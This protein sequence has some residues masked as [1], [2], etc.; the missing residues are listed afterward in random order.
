MEASAII[1]HMGPFL[2]IV[3]PSFAG[4]TLPPT[5]RPESL[6]F[7]P[8]HFLACVKKSGDYASLND[9]IAASLKGMS[10]CEPSESLPD[11]DSQVLDEPTPDSQLT[12]E[13]ETSLDHP[14]PMADGPDAAASSDQPNS[15]D[16]LPAK[17]KKKKGK[18]RKVCFDNSSVPVVELNCKCAIH[19]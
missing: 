14:Q 5:V 18:K 6:F 19:L 10:D 4:S 3:S 15:G 8:I 11:I 12:V 2:E 1:N 17:K 9:A 13:H 16:A 7:L